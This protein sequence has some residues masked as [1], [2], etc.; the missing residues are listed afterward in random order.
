MF[1]KEAEEY[2]PDINWHAYSSKE[3]REEMKVCYQGGAKLGYDKGKDGLDKATK[4]IRDLLYVYQLGKNE[5]AIAR[6]RAE[7]EQFLKEIEK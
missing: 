7:A 5:L 6:I 1:E 4:I 3:I 2:V